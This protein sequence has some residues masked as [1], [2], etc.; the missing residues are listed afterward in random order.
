MKNIEFSVIKSIVTV[1]GH[2]VCQQVI[3]C[4]A[5]VTIAHFSILHLILEVANV[6]G[7][8]FYPL[9]TMRLRAYV[10]QSCEISTIF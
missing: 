10:I 4:V 5:Y 6:Q 8:I 7:V 2:E 9:S 3:Y 1:I